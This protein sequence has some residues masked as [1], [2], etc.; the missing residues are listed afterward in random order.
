MQLTPHRLKEF[1]RTMGLGIIPRSDLVGPP[2]KTRGFTLQIEKTP[3][4]K[5]IRMM[6][7][8]S[9]ILLHQ[10][11]ESQRLLKQALEGRS[12][13]VKWLTNYSEVLPLLRLP[14]PPHLVFTEASL[15]DGTWT[16]VVKLALEALKPVR[17]IVVSRLIDMKLYVET[18]AGGAF[19]FIVPPMAR[20][21]LTH[22]LACAVDSVLSLRQPH[23]MAANA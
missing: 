13:K 5:G 11:T 15:P 10:P 17:V 21:E 19:D 8:I 18:M 23:A 16:D 20:D 12:I 22:V 6:E 2:R 4:V 14:D 1:S 9:A 7:G 3:D